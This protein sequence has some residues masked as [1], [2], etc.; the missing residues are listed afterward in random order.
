MDYGLVRLQWS[1]FEGKMTRNRR[2]ELWGRL[3]GMLAGA[4]GGGKVAAW[5]IGAREAEWASRCA[6]DGEAPGEGDRASEAREGGGD[7]RADGQ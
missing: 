6:V 2:E 7:D 4:R 1:V 5:P 3:V